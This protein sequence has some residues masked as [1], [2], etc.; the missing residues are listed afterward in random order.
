[1]LCCQLNGPL[2]RVRC[3][4]FLRTWAHGHSFSGLR[5]IH[6][7][8]AAPTGSPKPCVYGAV[9]MVPW[10]RRMRERK[11]LYYRRYR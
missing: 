4:S 11:L 5:I 3:P 1:M 6:S 9:N 2:P 10:C 7:H 8:L